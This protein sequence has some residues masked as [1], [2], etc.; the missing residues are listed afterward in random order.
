MTVSNYDPCAPTFR[1]SALAAVALAAY[2][3]ARR[4]GDDPA[5]S[6]QAAWMAVRAHDDGRHLRAPHWGEA[7]AANGSGRRSYRLP[8]AEVLRGT[9]QEVGSH[10]AAWPRTRSS[11][12]A[13]EGEQADLLAELEHRAAIADRCRDRAADAAASRRW[14]ES[15]GVA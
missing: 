12:A 5:P 9:R 2:V 4:D 10:A 1:P 14:A 11:L 7:L 6:A 8:L 3:N 15:L 13:V